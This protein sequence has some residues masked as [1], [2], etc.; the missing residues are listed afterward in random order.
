MASLISELRRELLSKVL[1]DLSKNISDKFAW[2]VLGDLG[3]DWDDK[4]LDWRESKGDHAIWSKAVALRKA[5]EIIAPND[6]HINMVRFYSHY[7]EPGYKT[8]SIIAVGNWNNS[9]VWNEGNDRWED[10]NNLSHV[11]SSLFVELG[12]EVEWFDEWGECSEC[13]GLLRVHGDSHWW[14]E[15]FTRKEDGKLVCHVCKKNKKKS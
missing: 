14:R 7:S 3:N 13:N 12:M 2:N 10:I 1:E 6:S 9:Q 5:C 8:N 15:F 4:E 11:I